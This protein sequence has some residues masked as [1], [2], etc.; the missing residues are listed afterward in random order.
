[1]PASRAS[2]ASVPHAALPLKHRVLGTPCTHHCWR[3]P[4]LFPPSYLSL[5][6]GCPWK[7]QVR[8]GL[9]K[10]RRFGFVFDERIGGCVTLRGY[11]CPSSPMATP[12][13]IRLLHH[14]PWAHRV[15]CQ[16][17]SMKKRAKYQRSTQMAIWEYD[18]PLKVA[19]SEPRSHRTTATVQ[20]P[21]RFVCLNASNI[22]PRINGAPC[23]L[24]TP[25]AT[26][27][28]PVVVWYPL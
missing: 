1:M 8:Q 11:P 21:M 22:S 18:L 13:R 5:H 14:M 15:S 4:Q 26:G 6:L 24:P 20:I 23:D 19:T 16:R 27:R 17:W 25:P 2:R 28:G 9:P 10:M 7:S 12:T 3:P